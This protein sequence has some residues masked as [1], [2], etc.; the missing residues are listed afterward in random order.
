MSSQGTDRLPRNSRTN[1]RSSSARCSVAY[2]QKQMLTRPGM[3]QA[4]VSSLQSL[5][6]YASPAMSMRAAVQ[7]NHRELQLTWRWRTPTNSVAMTARPIQP[8]PTNKRS[9][10]H[11]STLPLPKV[12]NFKFPL[13]HR[14]RYKIT[15]YEEIGFS[16]LLR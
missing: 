8:A 9:R 12:I 14:Q 4:R 11:V 3:E 1:S 2:H 15:E 6:A 10:S 16:S 7:A 13:Q 5:T